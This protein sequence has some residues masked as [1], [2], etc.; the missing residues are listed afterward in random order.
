MK[1]TGLRKPVGIVALIAASLLAWRCI[2][3]GMADLLASSDPQSAT[4]SVRRFP[5][6]STNLRR[7][8]SLRIATT[9]RS[10]ARATRSRAIPWMGV[11]TA[12]RL[13]SPSVRAIACVPGNC[14]QWPNFARR[15]ILLHGSSWRSCAFKAGELERGVHEVDMLLRMQ[16]NSIP[17][18]CH[19]WS[20]YRLIR[21][22]DPVVHTLSHHP[23]WRNGFLSLLAADASDPLTAERIFAAG[24]LGAAVSE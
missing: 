21:Q 2:T 16:L 3:L 6:P 22:T 15:A 24:Q 13:R 10:H 5:K 1:R 23:A 12:S 19:G 8:I 17:K 9:P 18:C 11:R 20:G 7:P 4:H 14:S